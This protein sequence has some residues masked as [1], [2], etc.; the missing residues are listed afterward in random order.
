M[1]KIRIL[2][3]IGG[4]D[5]GGAETFLMNVLRKIDRE[6]FH[7][8]YLCY[9]EKKFD[10][11]DEAQKLGAEIVRIREPK[12]TFD[13]ELIRLIKEVIKEN[14]IDIVHAHTYYNSVYAAIAAKQTK[15]PF[16]AHSHNTK[17]D[18]KNNL[19]KRIYYSIS[20]KMINAYSNQKIACGNEA[21][22]AFYTGRFTVLEN[23]IDMMKFCY[24]KE[25]RKVIRKK[26]GIKDGELLLGHV[27]RFNEVKNHLFLVKIIEEAKNKKMNVKIIMVGDGP[28]KEEIKKTVVNNSLNDYVI[29]IPKTK[30]VSSLYSAMDLF[31]FPSLFEG[32]PM[33][34]MEAQ[35]N[36]L[37]ILAS[38]TIDKD[39][40]ISGN[41]HF[42]PIDSTDTWIKSIQIAKNKYNRKVSDKLLNSNYNI[43]KCV[44]KLENIYFEELK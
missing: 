44:Q 11:E 1:N 28:L 37:K 34:L 12:P 22:K 38:N 36:G 31:V 24:S 7:F 3:V 18:T 25:K 41:V 27:G 20:K 21:G 15:V 33:V 16:I 2:Q 23:G 30:D 9:G 13:F 5:M 42:L 35:A 32:L 39:S 4:L 26:M 10:Y 29:F 14:E 6:K 8:I 43:D 19:A 17:S 40:N